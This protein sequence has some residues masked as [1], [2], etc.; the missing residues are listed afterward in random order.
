MTIKFKKAN[1]LFDEFPRKG[2]K[3]KT[4]HYCPGCGHGTAHNLIAEAIDTLKIQD[5]TIFCSPVGCAVFGYF[6]FD[7]GNIQ[8]S[9][10][11]APAVASAVR[12]THPDS[13]IIS[14]Q[15]DGDL[16]GIGL[17]HIIHAANRGENITVFFINNVIYGMTGG[18]MAPTTLLGQKTITTPNGRSILNDGAPMKMCEIIATL[19]TPAYV[20]RVSIADPKRLLHA[21]KVIQKALQTQMDGKGFSF[22]EILCP[23]PI[24]WRMTPVESRQWMIDVMEKTYPLKCFT[25]KTEETPVNAFRPHEIVELPDHEL[26]QTLVG[27]GI[28]PA[29]TAPLITDQKVKIGGIG[30]QG[31]LSAGILL[32]AC[33]I[34]TNYKCTWVPSYGPEMR[35]GNSHVSI[36]ISN[37]PIDSPIIAHPNVL[38]AL[39]QSALDIDENSVQ[40]GGMIFVNSSLVKRKITRKDLH[41]IEVPASE[42]AKEIGAPAT[43]TTIMLTVYAI[44]SGVITP[45]T[46]RSAL[47][48]TLK[49]KNLLEMNLKAIDAAIAYCL[50]HNLT[51]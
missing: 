4:T 10:G 39:A 6:Y 44:V 2:A 47:E 37:A 31:I 14:Y 16:A 50:N 51:P 49:R 23:C 20:E 7:T 34:Q 25:D 43:L 1:A 35:G 21:R 12:R 45:K 40:S 48:T 18:Q 22:V 41:V 27:D 19:D 15:G 29:P 33:A 30:G 32:A 8:C 13:V 36:S 11:R 26:L 17:S 38:L 3:I 46:L 42:I 9:H 5:R 28:L 24:N